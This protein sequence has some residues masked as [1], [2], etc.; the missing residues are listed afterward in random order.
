[1]M[2]PAHSATS[3]SAIS[4]ARRRGV[5]PRRSMRLNRRRCRLLQPPSAAARVQNGAVRGLL[6]GG[7]A[8]AVAAGD[9]QRGRRRRAGSLEK[10][11]VMHEL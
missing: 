4:G 9:A 11:C 5:P 6:R 3:C 10:S 2:G 1:M 8:V 7:V